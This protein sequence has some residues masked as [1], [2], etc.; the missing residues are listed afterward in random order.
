MES[1]HLTL[2]DFA[3]YHLIFCFLLLQSWSSLAMNDEKNNKSKTY[4]S[5]QSCKKK[6]YN[7]KK[8]NPTFKFV[9]PKEIISDPIEEY[10][11]SPKKRRRYELEF[12]IIE[13][14]PKNKKRICFPKLQN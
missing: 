11:D 3:M 1:K 2:K 5:K 13:T 8:K 9:V 6:Q 14:K 7:N 12:K 10:K 4:I